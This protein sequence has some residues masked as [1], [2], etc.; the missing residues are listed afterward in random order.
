MQIWSG[1]M[2]KS[3]L[4]VALLAC[5][6]QSSCATGRLADVEVIDRA[7][8]RALPTYL[9]NGEHWVAGTP[10][11]SYA[12]ALRNNDHRRV[13]AVMSVDGVNV[14]SGASASSSQV[15]YVFE[16]YER[17]EIAGWRKSDR[18]IAG[19][20]FVA[21]PQ[22][23]AARTGRPANIGVIGV[24]VFRE[25]E[26]RP[27]VSAVPYAEPPRARTPSELGRSDAP[28]QRSSPPSP[29]SPVAPSAGAGQPLADADRAALN[30]APAD[31]AKTKRAEAGGLLPELRLGTGHGE[32]EWAPI[33]RTTFT[34]AS[35]TPNE[36]IRIRY[37]S[38]EN[39]VSMGIIREPAPWWF[40]SPNGR[41]DPFPQNGFVPDPPAMR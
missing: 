16:R 36:V 21:S 27:R 3:W 39:L 35:E 29:A 13:L 33:S 25:K 6:S 15:G 26:V 1:I 37:D 7:T 18:E 24:A 20:Q 34:R 28:M 4:A 23:Y 41:P 30:E 11:A 12:I 10:G 2:H 14:L 40:Q 31:A 22:S 8:G 9:H 38:R 5:V 17:G 19:F 32:R